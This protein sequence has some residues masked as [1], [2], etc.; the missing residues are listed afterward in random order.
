MIASRT[1]NAIEDIVKKNIPLV[2]YIASRIFIGK[3]KFVEL[4]DL[5]G[6]GMIGL[7]DS[8][9]K[10]DGSKGI[11][12]STYAS[13]R[14]KGAII[15][16]LRKISP[17]TKGVMDKLN[18]YNK[19]V[20]E[21]EKKLLREPTD[22]EIAKELNINVKDVADIQSYINYIAVVSLEDTLFSEDDEVQLIG[23]IEDKNSP[24]PEKTFD[25]KEQTAHLMKAIETLNEKDRT[26]LSLYY[27]EGFNLKEIGKV[28]EVS[29][30]RVSQLHSRAIMHLRGALENLKY[31]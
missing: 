28:L 30:S 5:V 2:K 15:D 4:E 29:E 8:I 17:I 27:Y 16:E 23:T 25:E 6:Y 21:L 7:M 3:D 18:K 11:K 31:I 19:A 9:K 26:V 14:I 24:N 1:S 10:Y 20:E 13:I 12:F 22:T